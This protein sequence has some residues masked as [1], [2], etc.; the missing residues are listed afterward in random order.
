MAATPSRNADG[1][2]IGIGRISEAVAIASR[3]MGGDHPR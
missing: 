2:G 3:L 1:I